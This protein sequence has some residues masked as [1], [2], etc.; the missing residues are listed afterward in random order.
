M[1]IIG[2]NIM[3]KLNLRKTHHDDVFDKKMKIIDVSKKFKVSDITATITTLICTSTSNYAADLEIYKIPENST[4]TATLLL[5]LD[6]SGSM[7]WTM[8][9]NS[10]STSSLKRISILKQGLRDVLQGTQT[11]PRVADKIVMGLATFAGN[12]GY[13]RIPAKPLGEVTGTQQGDTNA[14]KIYAYSYV[15]GKDTKYGPCLEW[16]KDL[17]CKSW[18]DESS[19]NNVVKNK[20]YTEANRSCPTRVDQNCKIYYK[21]EKVL[22]DKTHRDDLITVINGLSAN[23]GTP[24]PYAYAE[25]AAYL[26]WTSTK[27]NITTNV[28]MYFVDPN[29]NTYLKIG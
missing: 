29:D 24:T 25:A 7:D 13:I 3:R 23:G 16:N 19:N 15:S 22:V 5:L 11:T 14:E 27:S 12:N 20:G 4:G 2:G 26:M 28:Q 18:G 9:G 17:T 21:T 8:N 6:T 10:T 1:R